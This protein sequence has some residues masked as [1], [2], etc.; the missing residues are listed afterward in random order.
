MWSLQR[1]HIVCCRW[2]DH[3]FWSIGR[4]FGWNNSYQQFRVKHFFLK[5][6]DTYVFTRVH[7]S[8]DLIPNGEQAADSNAVSQ[9]F[10]DM[11]FVP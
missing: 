2:N 11:D 6:Y 5:S 7:S 3:I 9:D 10:G 4:S 8:P 1:Q